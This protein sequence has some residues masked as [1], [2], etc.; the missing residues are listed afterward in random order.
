M[1]LLPLL[2]LLLMMMIISLVMGAPLSVISMMRA[3]EAVLVYVCGSRLGGGGFI[4]MSKSSTWASGFTGQCK[5]L[6]LLRKKL[7]SRTRHGELHCCDFHF[8][9][10][11]W[12]GC[13]AE[14]CASE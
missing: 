10:G 9:T 12:F 6:L 1:L 14:A 2:L 4:L 7:C 13:P 8:F 5:L 11:L 3:W